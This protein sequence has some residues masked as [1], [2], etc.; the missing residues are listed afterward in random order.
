MEHSAVKD[1][2]LRPPAMPAALMAALADAARAHG[3]D[4]VGVAR[5]DSIP[6]A[7]ERLQ[8]FL[9]EGGHGDMDWLAATVPRRGDPRA[10]WP[11][12]R[13]V[14]MLGMN[15]GPDHDPLAILAQRSHGAISVYAQGDDYHEFMK[16][17]M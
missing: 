8:R 17:R 11:G 3:F 9:A 13:S 6:Q 2:T 12:V 10:L 16:P 14:I 7:L 4:V 5:P 15:Y 1:R